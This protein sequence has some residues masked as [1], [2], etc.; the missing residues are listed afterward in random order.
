MCGFPLNFRG[1]CWPTQATVESPHP[2]TWLVKCVQKK[3]QFAWSQ[4]CTRA[5]FSNFVASSAR[6]WCRI[7]SC[8]RVF[9][10]TE[11][12]ASI[13]GDRILPTSC[14][15]KQ[16][17]EVIQRH[18]SSRIRCPHYTAKIW[19][20]S[21]TSG[22]VFSTYSVIFSSKFSQLQWL[23]FTHIMNIYV[24]DAVCVKVCSGFRRVIRLCPK[25]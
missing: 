18:N 5:I 6:V 14:P 16:A 2:K 19:Q 9:V 12:V 15:R 24:A 17:L 7:Q 13:F 21:V 10:Y 8:M 4:Q 11:N 23:P 3:L 22:C 25:I 20:W 1:G